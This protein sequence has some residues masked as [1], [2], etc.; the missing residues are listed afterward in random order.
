M[1][2]GQKYFDQDYSYQSLRNRL[3]ALK[4]SEY[5]KNIH[6]I[7]IPETFPEELLTAHMESYTSAFYLPFSTID[8]IVDACELFEEY[9]L[10][11]NQLVCN[12][13]L[14]MARIHTCVI[15]KSYLEKSLIPVNK[16]LPS[17]LLAIIKKDGSVTISATH[18]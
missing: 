1:N 2:V 15:S 11:F 6:Q 4:V 8:A 17:T 16:N 14:T 12:Q 10:N 9:V 13:V 3:K 5:L 7:E 18:S